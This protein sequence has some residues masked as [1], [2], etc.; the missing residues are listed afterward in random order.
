MGSLLSPLI[1]RRSD[2]PLIES[3]LPDRLNEERWL[4]EGRWERGV[5]GWKELLIELLTLELIILLLV[6]EKEALRGS[7]TGRF[8][9][10]GLLGFRIFRFII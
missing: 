6:A 8:I 7:M 10:T 4:K 2:P 9:G 5:G 3:D 1:A